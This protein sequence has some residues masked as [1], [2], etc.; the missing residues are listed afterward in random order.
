M[1][2]PSLE[3]Y[4]LPSNYEMTW[5]VKGTTYETKWGTFVQEPRFKLTLYR[6]VFDEDD[7]LVEGKRYLVKE[8]FFTEDEALAR[9][10]ARDMGIDPENLDMRGLLNQVRMKRFQ[11]WMEEIFRPKKSMLRPATRKQTVIGGM[12]VIVEEYETEV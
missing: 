8:A 11:A 12:P 10:F 7:N 9:T 1:G 3:R 4:N 5:E 6:K 2:L